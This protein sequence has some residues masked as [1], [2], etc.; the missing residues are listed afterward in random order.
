MDEEQ[1]GGVGGRVEGQSIEAMKNFF[2]GRGYNHPKLIVAS[3]TAQ[4]L[5][6]KAAVGTRL[7][8]A[9]KRNHL[10]QIDSAGVPVQEDD[11]DDDFNLRMARYRLGRTGAGSREAPP[12]KTKSQYYKPHY[13]K[14]GFNTIWMLYDP[15][16][17]GKHRLPKDRVIR[18]AKELLQDKFAT[19]IY[20]GHRGRQKLW[21]TYTPV[22]LGVAY[23]LQYWVRNP[24]P[25]AVRLE[26]VDRRVRAYLQ[27]ALLK[28]RKDIEP[29]GAGI[30]WYAIGLRKLP[31]P[32][33][34]YTPT[35]QGNI[36][37]YTTF[38][39]GKGIL[40]SRP[41]EHER[42]VPLFTVKGR[43]LEDARNRAD[44]KIDRLVNDPNP[45]ISDRAL[46]WSREW[47]RA[48][49]KM[50]TRSSLQMLQK[51]IRSMKNQ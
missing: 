16:R 33:K 3:V 31:V 47:G 48:N 19:K 6:D 49:R 35:P 51:R 9:H 20:R 27:K 37:R 22:I 26:S 11:D 39:P 44:A 36:R 5:M 23:M 28:K 18:L 42:Y 32:S 12:L 45:Q 14:H 50:V 15:T 46:D 8:N 38:R 21:D 30:T 2:M 1:F 29:S 40:T 17:P 34:R 13:P 4:D 24:A 7:F 41:D 25:D 10:Q 43:N